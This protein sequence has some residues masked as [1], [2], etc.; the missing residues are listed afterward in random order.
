MWRFN[1]SLLQFTTLEGKVSFLN[2][3]LFMSYE[4]HIAYKMA[5]SQSLALGIA[6]AMELP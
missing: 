1:C 3:T 2:I 4:R 5:C 6:F